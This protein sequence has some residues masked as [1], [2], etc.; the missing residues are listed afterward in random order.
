M[1]I[2]VVTNM[3]PPHHLG[4]YELA[5][6]DAVA[7]WRS[8]GH[9]VEV[10]TS[11]LRFP[12]A[13]PDD[14]G[15]DTGVRRELKIYW[16]DG[17]IVSPAPPERVRVERNN[18]RALAAALDSFGPDVVSLWHM[19][20]VS[21]SLLTQISRRDIPMV[22]VVYDDWLVYGP[23]VDAWTRVFRTRPRLASLAEQLTGIPTTAAFGPHDAACVLSDW[24]RARAEERSK[25]DLPRRRS[26]VY[27]GIDLGV[28]TGGA[29]RPWRWRLVVAGRIE[30]RKGVHVA[31]E[32]LAQLD[33]ATLDV[34]GPDDDAAYA[35]QL[36]ERADA[37]G[38][39]SRITWHGAKSRTQLAEAFRGADVFV[40]PVIWDEPFGMVPLEAMACGAAVVATGT[41]GSGE[42]LDH[43]TNCLRVD[44]EDAAGIANSVRR[45]A[46]DPALRQ[47]LVAQGRATAERFA[48]TR[49]YDELERWHAAAA[50]RYAD[51]GPG[52]TP[53]G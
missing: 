2:L 52:Q 8:H 45:L 23:E 46:G 15:D 4:G 11:D 1:R 17:V 34:I 3:Y 31:I 26:V 5:C 42:F 51:S 18:Q 48:D 40:F 53:S 38:V 27:G 30:A 41:G 19:G 39:A 24:L 33:E 20:A 29:D 13:T 44:R 37:L 47:R 7:R 12:H 25:L 28:F 49:Y 16:R 6:R 36:R 14:A 43:E 50:N 35:A 21:L 10:L 22:A 9:D 32:A